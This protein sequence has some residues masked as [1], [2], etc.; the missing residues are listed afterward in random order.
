MP[1]PIRSAPPGNPGAGPWRHAPALVVVLIVLLHLATLE[2]APGVRYGDDWALYLLHARNLLEGRPYADTG[3]LY[4][5]LA[6]WY[7]PPTYP[8]GFPV[9]LAPVYAAFGLDF[10]ALKTV[11]AL[12][13]AGALLVLTRLARRD[14]APAAAAATAALVG[15]HPFLWDFRQHLLP[16][17]PF[18]F[19]ALLALFPID[20]SADP[21][22]PVRERAAWG[23]AAAAAVAAAVATRTIG[24]VL[25]PVWVVV[26]VLRARRP[27]RV[28][29]AGAAVLA[30][31]VAAQLLL[32]PAEAGYYQQIRDLAA[33]R[34]GSLFLPGPDRVRRLAYAL[35]SLWVDESTAGPALA[36]A[37]A[38]AVGTALLAAVEILARVRRPAAPEVF[39][40]GY[41]L[42]AFLWP[43][44]F[45]RYLVPVLPLLALYAVLGARRLARSG[46]AAGRTAVTVAAVGVAAVLVLGHADP[47]RRGPEGGAP[48]SDAVALYGFVRTHTGPEERFVTNHLPRAFALY[49][50]R[51]AAPPPRRVDDATFLAY[52]DRAGIGYLAVHATPSETRTLVER[53]PARFRRVYAN[54]AWDLV[55]FVPGLP[56]GESSQETAL[57]RQVDHEA[58]V[59]VGLGAQRVHVVEPVQHLLDAPHLALDGGDRLPEALV[60]RPAPGEQLR[61]EDQAGERVVQLVA[62]P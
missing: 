6:P 52:L 61:L 38:C 44:V 22:R 17:L 14:L 45:A 54:P 41:L 36:A 31:S 59:Q 26:L 8:P 35:T 27:G 43:A 5:P 55:R 24:L 2:N 29:L 9:L 40:V 25:V 15:L 30:V 60:P 13:F 19:F 46:G 3:Y 32:V 48:S 34:G 62:E 7:S 1:R 33:S 42:T 56:A 53:H 57:L 16:D 49:T 12:G 47:R 39:F 10:L 20:H 51:S 28:L 23:A 21:D 11:V 18:T 50:E 4:N 58:A 37:K